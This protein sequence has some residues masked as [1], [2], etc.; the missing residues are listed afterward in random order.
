MSSIPFEEIHTSAHLLSTSLHRVTHNTI[1]ESDNVHEL[2][3]NDRN[4]RSLDRWPRPSRS[5]LR[6]L[7]EHYG[8]ALV[9]QG[10]RYLREAGMRLMH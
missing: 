5:L 7:F 3:T 9:E 8:V 4:E 2:I 6:S 10:N 1:R